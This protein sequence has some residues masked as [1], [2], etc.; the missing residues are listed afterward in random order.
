MANIIK[1]RWTPLLF[2][3]MLS[4]SIIAI[5]TS[6]E[7]QLQDPGLPI[8][9]GLFGSGK[10]GSSGFMGQ[11]LEDEGWD[12]HILH[13]N[14]RIHVDELW[15]IKTAMNTCVPMTESQ[16]GDK[17]ENADHTF[18]EL[19]QF[20]MVTATWRCNTSTYTYIYIHVYMYIYIYMYICIT[21]IDAAHH[22]IRSASARAGDDRLTTAEGWAP[23][24]LINASGHGSAGLKDFRACPMKSISLH[25]AES[26]FILCFIV[27]YYTRLCYV[28]LYYHIIQVLG[29]TWNQKPESDWSNEGRCGTWIGKK[30]AWFGMSLRAVYHGFLVNIEDS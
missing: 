27:L 17:Y 5:A 3:T 24:D 14:L 25:Q 28:V 22:Q 18:C 30:V 9:D 16:V 4:L 2:H 19:M 11:G 8:G 10:A 6:L 21:Y 26:W 20:W 23:F 15:M 29:N 7:L 13:G 1:W 12:T